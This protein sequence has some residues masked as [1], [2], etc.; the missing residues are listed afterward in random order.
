MNSD[1]AEFLRGTRT[2][3]A[4]RYLRDALRNPDSW[5]EDTH[6]FIQ[7]WFPLP[8]LSAHFPGAPT[9]PVEQFADLSR[10]K[11][12]VDNVRRAFDRMAAFYGFDRKDGE[13]VCASNH[14]ERT[15]LWANRETHNDKRISRMI[16]SMTLFGL[17][18]DSARFFD[19]ARLAIAGRG[20]HKALSFWSGALKAG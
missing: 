3:H 7:W 19:V 12:I 16:R 11:K 10:E 9:V 4:G 14:R 18:D 8:D 20:D 2:D 15:E 6:D 1:I 5:L 17:R 13:L